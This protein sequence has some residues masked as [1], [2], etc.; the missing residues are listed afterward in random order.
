MVRKNNRGSPNTPIDNIEAVFEDEGM[1]ELQGNREHKLVAV[2]GCKTAWMKHQH[3]LETG[4]SPPAEQSDKAMILKGYDSWEFY[5][6]VNQPLHESELVERLNADQRMIELGLDASDLLN[7][8]P[9]NRFNESESQ[10]RNPQVQ[11]PDV[12]MPKN[13]K[14]LLRPAASPPPPHSCVCIPPSPAP[15]V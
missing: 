9:A 14:V 7:D 1:L 8:S 12:Q 6:G 13:K 4:N 3:L 2:N 10:N 5:Q 11:I 15:P